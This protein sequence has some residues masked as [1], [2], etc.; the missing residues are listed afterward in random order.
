SARIFRP[1]SAATEAGHR[2]EA[3]GFRCVLSVSSARAAMLGVPVPA[4]PAVAPKIELTNSLGMKFVAVAGTGMLFCI[5]E[6][7]LKDYSAYAAEAPGVRG[8]WK[9]QTVYGFTPT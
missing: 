8:D 4:A 1:Q 7:R 6:T 9:K 5:H 2:R 3:F